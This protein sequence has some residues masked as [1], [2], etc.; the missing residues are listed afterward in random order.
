MGPEELGGDPGRGRV[1][2]GGV[3]AFSAAGRDRPGAEPRGAGAA[4]PADPGLLR[5]GGDRREAV[6][7]QPQGAARVGRA[8][9]AREVGAVRSAQNRVRPPG[10]P[11]HRAGHLPASRLAC[12]G[13][14]L[15]GPSGCSGCC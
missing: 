3:P 2:P 5:G 14:R 11:G 10:H 6:P 7:A 9:R 1:L 4:E 12:V 15:I 8:L 13:G